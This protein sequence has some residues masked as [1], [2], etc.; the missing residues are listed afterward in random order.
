M[1]ETVAP[2]RL[3]R[4]G[5]GSIRAPLVGGTLVA[6]LL[7]VALAAPLLAPHDP[8]DQDLLSALLPPSW[9]PGGDPAYLFG[10][11]SLGRDILSRLIYGARIAV[12]VAIVAAFLACLIGSLLGLIAGFYGGIVD[13]VVSRLIDVWMAFPPVLLS[14]VLAAVI[15]AG[16]STVIIAIVVID[17]TRFARVVRAEVQLNTQLDYVAAAEVVG[18]TRRRTLFAEVLPNILPLIATLLTVEMGIAVIVEAILSFVGLSVSSDTPT[19]GGMIAEGRQVIYQAPLLLALPIGCI[20]A[21][22]ARLQPPRRRAPR[23]A[24]PGAAAMSEPPR[25]F[26]SSATSTSR[27]AARTMRPCRS[28]AAL[29]STIAPGEVHGLVGESGAGK[30]M[31]A[32]AVFG[33]LPRRRPHH[34]RRRSGSRGAISRRYPSA[35][36]GRFS[37]RA[38][39]LIPQDPTTSLNPVKR[40][41]EQIGAVLRQRL[42]LDRAR[43]P[44]ARRRAPRRGRHPRAGARASPSIRTRFPAAC[45]SAS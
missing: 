17:W 45:A 20:V 16:L 1:A 34:A 37:A 39:A 12:V 32:R 28:F 43:R 19:W 44:R 35:T 40:V 30:S 10:T 22:R 13:Q 4:R 2:A 31:I 3:A 7:L 27:F 5:S 11:D 9:S 38:I 26:S 25:R 36:A 8:L 42:G 6:V 24:R 21:H 18:L 14:I 33:L 23:L 41:G 15:G 29:G